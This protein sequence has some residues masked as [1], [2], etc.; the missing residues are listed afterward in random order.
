MLMN[1]HSFFVENKVLEDK[2]M[3]A[4]EEQRESKRIGYMDVIR[5]I[6]ILSITM[7]HACDYSFS[8]DRNTFEE[9]NSVPFGVSV[10][11]GFLFVFSR[12]GVPLFLMLTGALLLDR[13]YSDKSVFNRFIKHNFFSLFVTTEIWLCI[14]FW[15]LQLPKMHELVSGN[16]DRYIY[17]YNVLKNFVLNQLFIDQT[18]MAS[19]WYMPMILC[20]Y[21]MIP[22]MSV[23]IKKIDGRLI[24]GIYGIMLFGSMILPNINALRTISG[25]YSDLYFHLNTNFFMSQYW[26]FVFAGYF[27]SK[28]I[29]S[30][31]KTYQVALVCFLS[32]VFTVMF[33]VWAYSSTEDYQVIYSDVGTL[34]ASAFLFELLRRGGRASNKMTPL[35]EKISKSSFGIYFVHICIMHGLN[36]VIPVEKLSF[37]PRFLML[38]VLSFAGSLIIIKIFSASRWCRKYLFQ[39][40]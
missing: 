19:M 37:L 34:V 33:Q 23:A 15:Y 13:D 4:I 10:V 21:L 24:A 16:I 30:K 35:F 38:E 29:L 3:L 1:I 5:T 17:I 27:V 22:I 8:I 2:G 20:V 14:M 11:K 7:N 9:F 31:W 25:H 6:A 32:Y 26:L 12:L 36:R 28:G 39:I 18:T 40:K